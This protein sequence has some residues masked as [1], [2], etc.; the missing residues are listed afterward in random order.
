MDGNGQV[1]E[2]KLS[3]Q[4]PGTELKASV[5]VVSQ[6]VDSDGVR[7]V[8]LTRAFKGLTSA[9]YTF[10]IINDITLEYI[11]AVG[12]TPTL[13]Y[14]HI[15]GPGSVLLTSVSG[16]AEAGVC[17]C[18]TTPPA[19]GQATGMFQYSANTTQKADVGQGSAKFANNCAPQPRSDLLAMKNP[20]C[21]IRSY[22]GGQ[23]NC[24][25]MWSL[26]DADQ[27]IPW[28]D[29]PLE[30]HLKFRFHVQPYNA[31]YHT[32]V[33]EP[34]AIGIAS[35]V[36]FDIPKCDEGVMGCSRNPVDNSWLHTITGPYVCVFF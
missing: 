26:L 27:D 29:Q 3:D 14:H 6:T 17:I 9:Y 30:Y 7:H 11:N 33:T 23:L 10:D 15:R 34:T 32:Q 8:V 24:F 36:E 28:V 31:S 1:T 5:K 2:R 20:T 18:A 21:D 12:D 4:N 19:F 35:P 13:A 22:V 25:H 16:G